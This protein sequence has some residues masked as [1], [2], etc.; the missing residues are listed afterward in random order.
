ME[1]VVCKICGFEF[2]NKKWLVTRDYNYQGNEE[3][4]YFECPEC[5]CLQIERVPENLSVYY[6]EKY[7]SFSMKDS[8]RKSTE[9]VIQ[10]LM[11]LR[12]VYELSGKNSR[13]KCFAGKVLSYI[14]PRMAYKY[15]GIYC[16]KDSAI[17]DLGCGDGYLLR[18][19]KENGYKDL[20]GLDKFLNESEEDGGLSIRVG[21]I[22]DTDRTFEFI[23]LNHSFEHMD[24][25]RAVL[26]EIDKRLVSGG[27]CMICIP[28]AGSLAYELYGKYWVQLD[29][30][31]HLFLHSPKSMEVLLEH[32]SLK[33]REIIY[34]SNAFQFIGSLQYQRG[35][36]GKERRKPSEL[37]R[38][39]FLSLIKYG[40]LAKKVN[41]EKCGDQ[42]IFILR[43]E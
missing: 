42:A 11:K 32:T 33:I 43:K 10:K 37:F 39:A 36:S 5:H 26:E 27:T 29:A 40:K 16:Q 12:D 22:E 14:L 9:K 7:Y 25:P 19:L 6:G 20:T 38:F 28:V 35:I 23:M 4:R 8:Q 18:L 34:D 24:E 1:K 3:F 15:I 2:E 17:L 30:P 21:S 31:R 13:S 41:N